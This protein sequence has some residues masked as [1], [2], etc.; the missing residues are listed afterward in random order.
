MTETR[1]PFQILALGKFRLELLDD[2]VNAIY[3]TLKADADLK[4]RIV[5]KIP[6]GSWPQRTI[7]NPVNGK[8]FDADFMLQLKEE[9]AWADDVK[10]YSNAV[11]K[12]LD[13]HPTY[14]SMSHGRKCRCVYIE[15]ANNAMHVDV[16]PSVVLSDGRKVIVNRDENSWENTNPEGFTDWMKTKDGI[17]NGNLR[18]VIRRN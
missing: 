14:K 3:N 11:Y 1:T 6:R 9:P 13:N 10:Q 7:I 8:P 18:K 5:A 2:R 17:T 15:Y 12:A 16:V 4:D